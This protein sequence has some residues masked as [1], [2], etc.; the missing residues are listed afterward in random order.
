MFYENH[1]E[2]PDGPVFGS[3]PYPSLPTGDLGIWSETNDGTE[4]CIAAQLNGRME[5]FKDQSYIA[6][7]N[8]ASMIRVY[9]DD[10][11]TWPD[12]MSGCIGDFFL[13]AICNPH[14]FSGSL[15]VRSPSGPKNYH[16]SVMLLF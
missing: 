6:L 1:P 14:R 13:C 16:C 2:G 3:D 5:A 4:A 10:G 12:D 7:M 15:R 8:V 9:M 11:N